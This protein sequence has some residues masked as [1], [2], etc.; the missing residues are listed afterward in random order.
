MLQWEDLNQVRFRLQLNLGVEVA[1]IL[2][3][4]QLR[5]VDSVKVLQEAGVV[6]G[7]VEVK[8][9][10]VLALVAEAVFDDMPY[11]DSVHDV[12]V[13]GVPSV[14]PLSAGEGD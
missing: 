5:V 11:V 7:L 10:P 9:L 6:G 12:V 14:G 1:W 4:M 13:H 8:S 2:W 3:E